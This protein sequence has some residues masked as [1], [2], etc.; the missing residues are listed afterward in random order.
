MR[1]LSLCLA[2]LLAVPLLG[3][4]GQPVPQR[5][6]PAYNDQEKANLDKISAYLNGIRSL[7]AS[8]VQIGPEGGLDQ[9]EVVIQKPGQIRFSYR[10]PSPLLVVATGGSLYV[11]NARLNTVDRYSLSET[12]LGL[13]LNEKLDLKSNKAVMGVAEQNGAFVVRARTSANRN[14]ANITLVFSA[15]GIELR[16]WTVRD[17]QG[18]NTTV[19]LQS[20]QPGA[21]LDPALFTVPTKAVQQSRKQ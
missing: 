1:R 19:A 10:A 21:V 7:K 14:D 4:A 16:Q 11:K 12:P 9:G 2:V 5:L 17:D 13:L 3:G 18:G 6:T 15:P 8:F 20:L